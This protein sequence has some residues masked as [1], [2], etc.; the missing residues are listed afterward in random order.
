MVYIMATEWKV[1]LLECCDGTFL[2]LPRNSE[3]FLLHVKGARER[4]SETTRGGCPSSTSRVHGLRSLRYQGYGGTE[5][6][7]DGG[8]A[9]LPE[10]EARGQGILRAHP[11]RGGRH[12]SDF[13]VLRARVCV[14]RNDSV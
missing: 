3:K 13:P 9:G 4:A 1:N 8:D 11:G 7:A 5:R 6:C 14:V 12:G 10:D 2:T